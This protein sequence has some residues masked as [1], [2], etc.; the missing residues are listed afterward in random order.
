MKSTD[1]LAT[2]TYRGGAITPAAPGTRARAPGVLPLGFFAAFLRSP[3]SD[4][5]PVDLFIVR[6]PLVGGLTHP[7]ILGQLEF[8]NMAHADDEWVDEKATV[9]R[10]KDTSLP[11]PPV[12]G[13]PP[14]HPWL[15]RCRCRQADYLQIG[16]TY[17]E[18]DMP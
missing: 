4:P 3:S 17:P 1:T 18:I 12:T 10:E 9:Q 6:L 8:A 16:T 2:E 14:R 7:G 15:S 5:F 13:N 11:Q